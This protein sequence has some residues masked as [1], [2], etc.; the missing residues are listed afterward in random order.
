[1]FSKFFGAVFGAALAV[2]VAFNSYPLISSAFN[3]LPKTEIVTMDGGGSIFTYIDKYNKM[4]AD[5]TFLQIDGVCVSACT[6][7]L[8]LLDPEDYCVSDKSLL[9]FH[10]A[11]TMTPNGMIF[12]QQMSEW[13]RDNIYNGDVVDFLKTKGFDFTADVNQE[14]YPLGI[15]WGRNSDVK[16]P[17]C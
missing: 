14:Q 3:I 1:M 12:N 2:M 9:G 7:F 6:F 4:R 13:V 5:G 16:A 10:G 11:Y 15:I 17:E 8:G